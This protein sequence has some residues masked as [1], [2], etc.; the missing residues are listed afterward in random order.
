M[1]DPELR[2][3]KIVVRQFE[4]EYRKTFKEIGKL[5]IR[6]IILDVPREHIH[7]VLKHAQQVDMLSEY[8][9]Y[10]FTSLDLHTIDLEDFQYGGTNISSFSFVDQSGAEFQTVLHDWQ[11]NPFPSRGG[12]GLA[13]SNSISG[14]G[15]NGGWTAAGELYR[16]MVQNFTTEVALMYDAVKLFATAL[17][18][19]DR[20][21]AINIRSLSC[22]SEDPWVYGQTLVNYMR[23]VSF[24]P[25]CLSGHA[26]AS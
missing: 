14:G 24:L 26:A 3:K 5:G 23:M 10:F 11:S 25:V 6:N 22:D 17:H 21:Q 1:K 4:E 13:S 15:G 20:S 12:H 8:H 18:D 2:E 9:N 19:L 16:S 7:T